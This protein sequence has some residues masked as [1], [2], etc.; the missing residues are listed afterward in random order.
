MKTAL[1][2][3]GC[4]PYYQCEFTEC[5]EHIDQ[6]FALAVFL[7]FTVIGFLGVGLPASL[8]VLLRRRRAMMEEAFLDSSDEEK[9]ED[10][11]EEQAG[12]LGAW[13]QFV[14]CDP[15]AL[16]DKYKDLHPRLLF[17]P[18]LMVILKV[19][20]LIPSIFLEPRS[21]DQ[22]IGCAV[23]QI[24]TALFSFSTNAYYSP[25]MLM[26]LRTAELHQLMQ[27]GLQN[28]DLVARNDTNGTSVSSVMVAITLIYI[29]FCLAVAGLTIAWPVLETLLRLNKVKKIFNRYHL[30]FSGETTLYVDVAEEE[31][32]A[33]QGFHTP[34]KP[35]CA[36]IELLPDV[37]VVITHPCDT[38]QMHYEDKNE[39]NNDVNL[40]DVEVGHF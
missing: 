13:C 33:V 1:M 15:S 9:G 25:I 19:V 22:R 16:A 17:F 7:A 14:D 40:T 34:A 30:P 31:R 6:K 8:F 36:P 20:T 11:P 37:N 3:V 21:L 29:I 24:I 4:H 12:T 23:V 5:W 2:I 27:L 38:D 39:T 32:D 26:A 28:I 18:S 35:A 10:Q